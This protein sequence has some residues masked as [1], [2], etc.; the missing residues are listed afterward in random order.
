MKGITL[1]SIGLALLLVGVIV[2]KLL[3][4]DATYSSWISLLRVPGVICFIIG[5]MRISREKRSGND[6]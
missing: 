6:V 3:S 2:P 5:L 4:S 1:L